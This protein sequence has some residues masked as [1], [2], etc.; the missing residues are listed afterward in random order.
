MKR[1]NQGDTVRKTKGSQWQGVVV[2]T[3]STNLTP[4]G[5]AVESST[6]KGSVQIYPAA[7]LELVAGASKVA[8]SISEHVET[9]YVEVK[10]SEVAQMRATIEQQAAEIVELM[11]L[12]GKRAEKGSRKSLGA[13][14]AKLRAKVGKLE[15]EIASLTATVAC[16]GASQI[17]EVVTDS[18]MGMISGITGMTPPANEPPPAFIQAAIDRAVDRIAALKAQPRSA[19]VLPEPDE[20]MQ[21]AFEEGQPAE[22]ASGYYFDLE[23]FDLFVQRLLDEVARLNPPGEC[24]AVPRD[25]LEKYMHESFPQENNGDKW[26]LLASQ[27]RA[28]LAQQGKAVGDE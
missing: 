4:E 22:D 15:R 26:F 5:Y 8:D 14:N 16:T 20:I 10:R 2:G 12:D 1:F 21:M 19:V 18:L 17:R 11:Q 13:M 3:Y 27:L 6:E 28:I 25:L 23:E 9:L 7:A 24:V